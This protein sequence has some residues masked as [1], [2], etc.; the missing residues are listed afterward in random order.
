VTDQQVAGVLEAP[1]DDELRH[2]AHETNGITALDN[3][4]R[5]IIIP[6]ISGS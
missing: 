2:T 6:A 3:V 4:N 5:A 1:G